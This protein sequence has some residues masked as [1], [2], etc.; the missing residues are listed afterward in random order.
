MLYLH[1][2]CVCNNIIVEEQISTNREKLKTAA[3]AIKK[4][5]PRRRICIKQPVVF[6]NKQTYTH[7]HEVSQSRQSLSIHW[8]K[9]TIYMQI[10][11]YHLNF[12]VPLSPVKFHSYAQSLSITV[13][14]LQLFTSQHFLFGEAGPVYI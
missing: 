12:C 10:K 3:S 9:K 13:S 2:M 6:A 11:R 14:V 8:K 4:Y 5:K 1:C 7:T